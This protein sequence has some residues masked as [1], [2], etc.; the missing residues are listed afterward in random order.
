[1]LIVAGVSGLIMGAGLVT[2]QWGLFAGI[3]ALVLWPLTLIAIPWYAAI[4]H[5]GWSMLA[6]VY[7]GGMAGTLLYRNSQA[8]RHQVEPDIPRPAGG[9]P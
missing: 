4:A 1:V 9:K 6:V 3:G 7:G 5:D 8:R 2:Q